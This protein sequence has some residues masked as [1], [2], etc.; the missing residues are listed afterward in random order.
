[1]SSIMMLVPMMMYQLQYKIDDVADII[2]R[3]VYNHYLW[4]NL[5]TIIIIINKKIKKISKIK[6]MYRHVEI[7][8][9]SPNQQGN[10]NALDR[11]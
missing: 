2:K 11:Q 1:M 4:Y 5:C 6:R 8:H 7:Y 3:L 9:W 10:G